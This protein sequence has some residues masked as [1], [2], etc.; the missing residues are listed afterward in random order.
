MPTGRPATTLWPL[1]A[2]ASADS[3]ASTTIKLDYSRETGNR[4]VI[5]NL[6]NAPVQADIGFGVATAAALTALD[7]FGN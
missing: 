5:V 2:Q 7:T 1:L 3:T 6:S 4:G